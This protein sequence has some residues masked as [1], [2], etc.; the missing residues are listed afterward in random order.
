MTHTESIN[1]EIPGD[2]FMES[3]TKATFIL[4][5][6]ILFL[7]SFTACSNTSEIAE[8]KEKVEELE[9]QL[10]AEESKPEDNKE[11]VIVESDEI[12]YYKDKIEIINLEMAQIIDDLYEW[13]AKRSKNEIS[14]EDLFDM[15]F[16]VPI[17]IDETYAKFLRI[18]TLDE[19]ENI[20]IIYEKAFEYYLA[21]AAQLNLSIKDTPNK[22]D[23]EYLEEGLS[24][25]NKGDMLKEKAVIGLY[26]PDR[27]DEIFAEVADELGVVVDIPET[28][29][30]KELAEEP[31]EE[32]DEDTPE[33]D[34]SGVSNE[35]EV[36]ESILENAKSDWPNDKDMQDFQ[37]KN[38]VQAYHEILDL[39]NTSDYRQ[40]I[41]TKAQADWPDDY[42][43]Q[44]FQYDNQL[45]AYHNIQNL[46][47]TSNYRQDIL[48]KAKAD[49]PDDYEMQL[50][51]Y[52]NQL[53]AY[54][55]I[56]NLPN[57]SDYNEAALNRAKSDWPKDYEM[58]LWQYNNEK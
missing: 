15:V 30:S 28:K 33:K 37:Y 53:E 12:E 16:S 55:E 32:V 4:S 9:S 1:F 43:M 29:T 57:T 45:E 42:E 39:P 18:Q 8:L 10:E 21:G 11:E 27:R 46:P 20:H 58:Q 36:L 2:D 25:F 35:E 38:Q 14:E 13:I 40:E 44:L 23:T 41:L 24:Y 26:N 19:M 52:N 51:Q 22:V 50:F 3:I 7:L 49:W 5:A 31:A 17:Y 56:Q 6:A 34:S 48:D 54:L 47:G